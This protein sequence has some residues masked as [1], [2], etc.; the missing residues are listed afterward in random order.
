[1]YQKICSKF[2]PHPDAVGR[3]SLVHF[4]LCNFSV[5]FEKVE[6]LEFEMQHLKFRIQT[7]PVLKILRLI[8]N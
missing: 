2:N 5:A 4:S 7:A 6:N 1:M 8:L 3:Y